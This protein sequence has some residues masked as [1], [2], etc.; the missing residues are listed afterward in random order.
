MVVALR[1]KNSNFP[2]E[3][4]VNKRLSIAML[5]LLYIFWEYFSSAHGKDLNKLVICY[6]SHQLIVFR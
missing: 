6:D 1:K 2:K 5:F 4:I 3:S